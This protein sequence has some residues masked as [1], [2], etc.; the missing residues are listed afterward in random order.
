M[1]LYFFI[2]AL[3]VCIP[4]CVFHVTWQ[5]NFV[6][7]KK[8]ACNDSLFVL[9]VRMQSKFL[10]HNILRTFGFL[11]KLCDADFIRADTGW[12]LPKFASY[13]HVPA[14]DEKVLVSY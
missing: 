7:C 14:L 8:Y 9:V 1:S 3:L 10:K 6:A 12:N 11:C 4:L 13:N 5:H 2:E